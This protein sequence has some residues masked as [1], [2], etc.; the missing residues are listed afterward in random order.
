MYTCKIF[1]YTS[2]IIMY[3]CI[4]TYVYMQDNYVYMQDNYVYMQYIYVYMQD[5]YVYMQDNYLC[6]HNHI[7]FFS[8][9]SKFMKCNEKLMWGYPIR[10]TVC[11]GGLLQ[12][13]IWFIW[14]DNLGGFQHHDLLPLDMKKEQLSQ[15]TPPL[16]TAICFECQW[17]Y[18]DSCHKNLSVLLYNNL[19]MTSPYSLLMPSIKPLLVD[20]SGAGT[21]FGTGNSLGQPPVF[22]NTQG[23]TTTGI[24][25]GLGRGR[26]CGIVFWPRGKMT[27]GQNTI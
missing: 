17:Y 24:Q 19:A 9:K 4:D 8:H 25:V 6:I 10:A 13:G 14:G 12:N 22:T 23:V 26:R 18:C 7:I 16:N 1:M 27:P 2:K 11:I 20:R 3:T 15:D 21:V 5:N